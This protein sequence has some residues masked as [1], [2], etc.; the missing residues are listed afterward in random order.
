[1]ELLLDKFEREFLTKQII[2]LG[3]PD[4]KAALHQGR[5]TNIDQV[6]ASGR[7]WSVGASTV[8]QRSRGYS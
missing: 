4:G 3:E 1:M 5:S 2:E 8:K 6:I 7:Q